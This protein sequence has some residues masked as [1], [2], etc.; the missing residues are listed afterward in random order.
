MFLVQGR[1][2][3]GGLGLPLPGV[4]ALRRVLYRVLELRRRVRLRVRLRAC[5]R[6]RSMR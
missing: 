5:R 2:L 6:L 3:R 4:Q 1:V